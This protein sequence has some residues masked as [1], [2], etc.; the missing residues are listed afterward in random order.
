M[1]TVPIWHNG[2]WA[3]ATTNHWTN[4]PSEDD[5][6]GIPVTWANAYQL[7]MIKTLIGIKPVN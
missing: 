4:W 2:L 1:P 7:G 3:Q 6:Y 5:P